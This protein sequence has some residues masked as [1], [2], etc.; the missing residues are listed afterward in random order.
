M[1]LLSA[2]NKAEWIKQ[3]SEALK[4]DM[5]KVRLLTWFNEK[6]SFKINSS[7][8]SQKAFLNYI[9]QDDFFKSGIM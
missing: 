5:S 7:A 3:M 6:E 9:I 1:I 8:E 4:S 2:Q